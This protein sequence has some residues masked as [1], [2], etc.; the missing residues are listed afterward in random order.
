MR[1]LFPLF[2]LII[3]LFAQ[4]CSDSSRSVSTSTLRIGNGAEPSTLDPH[5]ATSLAE[6]HILSALFEGLVTPHPK[7]DL[8]IAPGVAEKWLSENN[9]TR[10]TF[11]LRRNA[12]WSDGSPIAARDFVDAYERLLNPRLRAGNAEMLYD[13]KNA[14]RYNNGQTTDFSEVG[15]QATSS[16]TLVLS[17]ERPVLYFLQKLKHWS[18]QPVH[19]PSI[20]AKGG[21]H[22]PANNWASSASIV[23]NGPYVAKD[24]RRNE[25]IELAKN[26]YYWDAPSVSIEK[27]QFFPYE[28]VQTEFRAFQ[29]GQLDITEEV[30][31]EQMDLQPAGLRQDPSLATTYLLLNNRSEQLADRELR[32]SLSASIDRK[33]L[34]KAIEKSGAP[35]TRFTPGTMPGYQAADFPQEVDDAFERPKEPLRFLVS[36]RESSIAL[37]EAIQA[38]WGRKLGIEVRIQNMEFKSLLARLDGGDYDVSLLAWHGDYLDPQTFLEIWQ[39]DSRFNRAN[40]SQPKFDQLIDDSLKSASQEERFSILAEAEALIGQEMP[41]IPLFWKTKDYLISQRVEGWSASLIDLRSYK[42]VRLKP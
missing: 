25:R 16:H 37:A 20:E 35:A 14:E 28:N 27:I 41:I 6:G 8:A 18:W 21:F 39:S 5:L 10:Y 40:W 34:I 17:L 38:I 1:V 24:W 7:D 4:G 11:E 22:D 12:K 3:A 31:S 33:L 19:R 30:P 2:L 42:H 29:A 15:V 32:Q 13:L 26:Q 23:S 36:N 9:Y